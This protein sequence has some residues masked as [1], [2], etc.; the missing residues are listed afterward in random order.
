MFLKRATKYH[1][2]EAGLL[3]QTDNDGV[4]ACQRA[5]DKY[6]KKETLEIIGNCIPFDRPQIPILHHVAKHA[7]QF[8]NDFMV[9]YTSAAYLRDTDGRNLD[10][11]ILASGN[12]TFASDASYFLRTLSDDQVREIDPASD[13]YPFMVAASGETSDLSAVYVLLR[14]NP[15]LARG[16]NTSS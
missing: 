6:G 7:F 8:L 1:T 13:L 3:F 16:G 2:N 9:R 4:T 15:S 12:K 14:R 11:A 5:F 10:Q